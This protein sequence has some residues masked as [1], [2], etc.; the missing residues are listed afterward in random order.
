MVTNGIPQYEFGQACPGVGDDVIHAPLPHYS[1][2]PFIGSPSGHSDAFDLVFGAFIR[3]SVLHIVNTL[4]AGS[5]PNVTD[6][7][8]QPYSEMTG[9][10]AFG[11]FA[12]IMWN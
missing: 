6:A 10:E 12:S 2:P 4:N 1:K 7:D 11:I 5:R 3:D 9:S 8:I